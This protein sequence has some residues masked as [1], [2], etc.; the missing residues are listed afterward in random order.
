[1][2]AWEAATWQGDAVASAPAPSTAAMLRTQRIIYLALLWATL[3]YAV[4]PFFLDVSA[5]SPGPV[6]VLAFAVAALGA[7][8]VSV[9]LP[10]LMARRSLLAANLPVHEVPD[11]NSSVS[12]REHTPTIRVFT[13]PEQALEKAL[14][15]QQVRLLV[16]LS[17]AEA[18]AI[19]GFLVALLGAPWLYALPFFLLS[20]ALFLPRF[21]TLTRP[22]R[23]LE[24]TYEAR[25]DP[26]KPA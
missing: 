8:G 22:A 17:M 6:L 14:G 9:V 4:L 24:A 5:G 3:L 15:L 18:V 21:P 12:F 25:L 13:R 2:I 10:T 11:P 1:M 26:S 20:W 16:E 23:M 19:F 7:A